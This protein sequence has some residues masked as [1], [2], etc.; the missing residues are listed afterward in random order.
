MGK[1]MWNT[2]CFINYFVSF[3]DSTPLINSNKTG[4]YMFSYKFNF[5]NQCHINISYFHVNN[6]VVEKTIVVIIVQCS[7]HIENM[8]Y[9]FLFISKNTVYVYHMSTG[10][11]EISMKSHHPCHNMKCH[12]IIW[13]QVPI[14]IQGIYPYCSMHKENFHL[15]KV[16]FWN[17]YLYLFK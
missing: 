13:V 3:W 15:K 10:W 7:F 17:V 12:V 14:Q 6:F 8:F 5:R 9:C 16:C 11:W 4:F 2:M 1:W